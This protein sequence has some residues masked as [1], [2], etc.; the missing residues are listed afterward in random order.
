MASPAYHVFIV[1]CVMQDTVSKAERSRKEANRYGDLAKNAQPAY[2]GDVYRKVAVRYVFMAE[3]LLK[4]AEAA[5][6][7]SRNRGG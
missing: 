1:G 2:L 7:P 5:G 4:R 3:D 6:T